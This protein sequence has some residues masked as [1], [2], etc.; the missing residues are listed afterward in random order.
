MKKIVVLLL[1][2]GVGGILLGACGNKQEKEY[3]EVEEYFTEKLGNKSQ[4][5]LTI[6]SRND[7]TKYCY[8][9][10]TENGKNHSWNIDYLYNIADKTDKEPT[11]DDRKRFV[12]NG[13]K[14]YETTISYENKKNKKPVT[15]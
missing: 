1:I 6:Y 13:E 4:K 12:E 14:V 10:L 2:L 8:V 7:E 3:K 9:R 11:Q 5:E 15:N